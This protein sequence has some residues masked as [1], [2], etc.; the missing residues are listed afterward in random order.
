MHA[1]QVN[2]FLQVE[3]HPSWFALGDITSLSD[4]RLGRLA[5]DQGALVAAQIKALH[6][7]K[8]STLKA[9]KKHNGLDLIA[10]S[11]G[12]KNGAMSVFGWGFSGWAPIFIKSKDL[13]VGM[14]RK[15]MGLAA[16]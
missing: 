11:L 1:V 8:E 12:R 4:Y 14:T 6:A 3:G 10:V 7:R 13:M 5:S 16:V 2:D 9:W 15:N